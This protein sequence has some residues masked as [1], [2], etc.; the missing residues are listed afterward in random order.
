MYK[1]GLRYNR[2][3]FFDWLPNGD[4]R[5]VSSGFQVIQTVIP[6]NDKFDNQ[7]DTGVGGETTDTVGTLYLNFGVANDRVQFNTNFNWWF[8]RKFGIAMLWIDWRPQIFQGNFGITPKLILMH[9]D[10]PLSGDM[11]LMRGCSEAVLELIYEF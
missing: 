10:T 6:D 2:N 3:T 7:D 1:W 11:G 4:R 8:E 5:S 9:G